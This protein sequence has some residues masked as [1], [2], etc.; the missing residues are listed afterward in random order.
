MKAI[1]SIAPIKILLLA[2]MLA[3]V[4]VPSVAQVR[5]TVAFGPPALPIYEQPVCPG[6]GYIWIPGYWAFDNDFDNDYWVP[7]TWVLAPERWATFGLQAGGDGT[8]A[9][10]SST[11]GLGAH[12]LAFMAALPTA[13]AT[14]GKATRV[15]DGMAGGSTTT[16]P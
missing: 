12:A 9:D 11:T 10:L 1:P 8:T 2:V 15:G 6:E 5:I 4:S 16:V 7:G 13:S 14:P 3:V